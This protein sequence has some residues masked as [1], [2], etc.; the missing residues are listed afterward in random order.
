MYQVILLINVFVAICI[1]ALVLVQQ[2]KGA[3]MGA[4]FGS[5]ASQTVFGSR[6]SGS[7]LFRATMTFA[8]IFFV[9]CIALNYLVANAYKQEKSPIAS[10]ALLEEQSKAKQAAGAVKST[11]PSPVTAI[12][13]RK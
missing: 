13:E 7:F 10:L 9:T 12:P 6:G 1:I 11:A 2:G 5:G 4:A 3:T 8:L